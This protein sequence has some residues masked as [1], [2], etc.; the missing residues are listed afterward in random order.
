MRQLLN[1]PIVL[2]GLA[3]ITNIPGVT[4]PLLLTASNLAGIYG[5]TITK[6]NDP[7]LIVNNPSLSVV[8]QPIV[9]FARA[10]GSGSTN[11]LTSF[12]NLAA[13]PFSPVGNGPFPLYP[14]G[15][16]A[17]P[18]TGLGNANTFFPIGPPPVLA[19][20]VNSSANMTLAVNT[21]SYSIG[22]VGFDYVF[23]KTSMYPNISISSIQNSSGFFIQPAIVTIEAAA[24]GQT[25]PANL[26]LDFLNTSNPIGYPISNATNVIV[27]SC[28]PK[29]CLVQNLQNFLFFLATTGQLSANSL[30]FGQLPPAVVDQ[31]KK[32]LYDIHA[33]C[34]KFANCNC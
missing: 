18:G 13:G 17:V 19:I 31:Y 30:G 14:P 29:C 4:G 1:F 24:L 2:F 9:A 26:I 34:F 20:G 3:I 27:I 15:G 11:T 6:W 10:D 21:I 25:V 32:Q 16:S 7:S 22:Y 5:G 28:Q 8:N 33:E 12:L 23:N